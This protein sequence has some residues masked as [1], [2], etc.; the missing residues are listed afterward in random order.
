MASF[1]T[2][3]FPPGPREPN[4]P[5]QTRPQGD[6]G[7]GD[8]GGP[9]APAVSPFRNPLV[10][11]LA[12]LALIG[13]FIFVLAQTWTEVLWFQQLEFDRVI[14]TRWIASIVLGVLAFIIMF[15]AIEATVQLA[16]KRRPLIGTRSNLRAY[17]QSI[18]PMRNL[19][20]WGVPALLSLTVAISFSSNWQQILMWFN[21]T[22]F[23]EVDP[24]FGI[25]IS[26]YVFTVPVLQTL[27]GFAM[28]VAVF[29][30]IGALVVNYL[31]GG[32]TI[33]PRLHTT[34][35]A[36]MQVGILAAIISLLFGLR[37][38]LG[39]YS[40]LFKRT[41]AIVDG[42]LYTDVNAFLPAQMILA[43][44]S[45]LV[46]IMFLVAAFRGTWRLPVVGVAVTIVAS[47]VVGIAYPALIQQFRV[48][49]NARQMEQPFIQRN[50][51]ATLKAYGLDDVEYQTYAAKTDVSPGQLREDSESTSQIRLL[52]PGVVSPTFRQLQQSRPYY[53]FD[54]QLSVDRYRIEG[55]RRD[56]V[57]AVR[58]LNLNGLQEEQQ[59]WVNLHTVYTHGF[60]VVAAYGSSVK[61]DGT[62]SFW[63]QS[64]PSEGEIGDYEERV[65]FSP[66]APQ[67]SIVGA[68]EG[69]PPQELDYPDDNAASGQVQTTFTG[70]GGPSVGNLFNKLLF[71]VKFGST[72]IFFSSQ[73]NAESQILFDRDPLERIKKVAPF[74]TLEQKA[75][76][77]VVD[78]DD[79]P[80]TPQRL[81]WIVD[82]YTTSNSYPYAEHQSLIE[83]TTDS[84]TTVGP[85]ALQFETINYIRNSVKA[86]VDAYDG[87]VNLYAWDEEDPILAAWQGVYP[88]LVEG[89]DQIS[90]D[91][92][93]HLRYPEDMFKVQ[94]SLLTTYHVTEA[95][96]FYTGGDRWR[97]SE[98]PTASASDA[99]GDAMAQKLQPPYYLTMQMPT[100]ETAEFSLTSVYVPAGGGEARRAAMAG[101][102]AVDSETG[103]EPGKIREDYGKLRLM[104][105]PSSTT[106]PGPGQVQNAFNSDQKIAT[107]LNLLNQQGSKV[108]SGNLLTL[109]VGGGL[110]YVQPVYVES[111]GSTSYPV[112]RYVLTAFGDQIGFS[113]TLQESLDQ[114]FGGDS[115]ATI[116]GVDGEPEDADEQDD[117]DSTLEQRLSRT[118]L[119]ARDAMVASE[120]A[121][122]AGDWA[123]YGK[124]QADLNSA[125]ERA[126]RIQNEI[127]DSTQLVEEESAALPEGETGEETPAGDL[128]PE[129]EL[130]EDASGQDG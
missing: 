20:F 7:A 62:P 89:T 56:T 80:S 9:E 102:L 27:L 103:S 8:S 106:V 29:S 2:G 104:A 79:D 74:L 78:M 113:R 110:L 100:Q 21:R 22:P 64:I 122:T 59:T 76:P 3:G 51:D 23:G 77:A 117:I 47:L 73:T 65:Y 35:A 46:S 28:N 11:T 67:Y 82:A 71:A 16:Y 114:T 38:W 24:Q 70:D 119:Q 112:L 115:A 33:S 53:T 30:L 130:G 60:G 108:I 44:V 111:T 55:E 13:L 83:A 91:L 14:W 125:L 48:T 116:A 121:L 86:V 61:P 66:K 68:P 99:F 72:D 37:Y 42:A 17:Q 25:D 19:V 107:E 105:L 96:E 95:A 5:K 32:I 43:V 128:G 4:R 58:D 127:D 87:S 39:I 34:K 118:L 18:E 98:D 41:D 120:E 101:F 10:I 85:A 81:V 124:A 6:G 45:L 1:F 92:M 94:R 57:I 90:G 109:P 54:E 31:Y 26:F 50:I 63:E 93:S 84:R 52:D 88:G 97:L 40:M 12:I 126:L 75:Y 129:T 15:G 36:R 123:A 49:P 69:T